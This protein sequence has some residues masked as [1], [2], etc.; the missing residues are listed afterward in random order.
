MAS[1]GRPPFEPDDRMRA[2]VEAWAGVGV[3]HEDI[4]K[5][6][7][8][9]GGKPIDAKTLRKHF[10]YEL[11]VGSIKANANVAANMYKRATGSGRD[12]VNAGKFWLTHRAGWK[13]VEKIELSGPDGAPIQSENTTLTAEEKA[14][15]TA[16]I[17]AAAKKRRDEAAAE[18]ME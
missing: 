4:A 2:Q 1:R 11:D 8:T 3:P 14:H 17:L 12:A 5:M 16:L 9:P 6:L 7:S 15:R 13:A 10:R 18:D